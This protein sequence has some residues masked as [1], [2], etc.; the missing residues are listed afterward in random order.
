MNK[1]LHEVFKTAKKKVMDEMITNGELKTELSTKE[2]VE[3]WLRIAP[4]EIRIIE[5]AIQPEHGFLSEMGK[6]TKR[7]YSKGY[8]GVVIFMC[9]EWEK[10]K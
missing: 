1:P 2:K 10:E 4:K 8:S 3:E 5:T 6:Y 9:S 7:I